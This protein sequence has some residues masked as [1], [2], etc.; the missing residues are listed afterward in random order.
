MMQ[1]L[2]FYLFLF[3]GPLCPVDRSKLVIVVKNLAVSLWIFINHFELFMPDYYSIIVA[4]IWWPGK[5]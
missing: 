1:T 3:L 4:T 5:H 2:C